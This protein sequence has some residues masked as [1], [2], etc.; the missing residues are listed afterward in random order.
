MIHWFRNQKEKAIEILDKAIANLDEE[1]SL[2]RTYEYD[3]KEL[4]NAKKA[5][6]DENT[7]IS[8]KAN[9]FIQWYNH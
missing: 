5:I 4:T 8:I 1:H 3:Y 9:E 2:F 7:Y 6:L